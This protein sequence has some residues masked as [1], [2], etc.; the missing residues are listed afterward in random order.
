[1]VNSLF[2]TYNTGKLTVIG[3]ECNHLSDYQM[4]ECNDQLLE[5]IREAGCKYL[6]VDLVDVPIVKSWVLGIL[7][8]IHSRGVNVELYN[9]ST[10]M[11]D[12]MESTNLDS[13]LNIRE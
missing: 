13:I 8:A 10:S 1:M 4:N 5:L 11:R 3:F 2:N 6:V 12:V 7:A 9:L